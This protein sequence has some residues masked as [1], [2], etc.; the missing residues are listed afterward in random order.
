[1]TLQILLIE[2][3]PDHIELV[4]RAFEQGNHLLVVVA[5]LAEAQ[6]RLDEQSFDLIICDL[7][8]PDGRG[9][10]LLVAGADGLTLPVVLMTGYGDERAAVSA[11][12]SGALDYVAKTPATLLDLP[13]I[14]ERAL[15]ERRLIIERQQAEQALRRSERLFRAMIERSSDAISMVDR[16]GFIRYA[17]PSTQTLLGY[18]TEGFLTQPV[19]GFAFIHPADRERVQRLFFDI[20]QQSG[21]SAMVEFRARHANGG[22]RWIEA[23][24]SNWLDDPAVQG[25]IVNYR[26][27]TE[28]KLM[29]L[30]LQRGVLHDA[31]TG[32]P[33][34]VLLSDRLG[35][36]IKRSQRNP[37]YHFAV[38]FLDL[39]HFKV[40]ND[41]FGH[42]VG[43]RFLVTAASR[44]HSCLRSTDTC[45]R[46][47]GDEF[48][49]LLDD[50]H[51]LDAVVQVAR[52]IIQQLSLPVEVDAQMLHSSVSIGIVF[53][54]AEYN[55]P[56][57]VLRDAD[58][59]MYRA[60]ASGK[61]RYEVFHPAMREA[62]QARLALENELRRAV[63]QREFIVYYQPIMNISSGGLIGFEAL[64]RWQ[65][66]KRGILTPA[67]FLDVAEEVGLG[68]AIGWQVLEHV[69][70][71]LATWQHSFPHAAHLSVSVNLSARQFTQPD[72]YVRIVQLLTQHNIPPNCLKLELT[73]SALM[74]YSQEAAAVLARLRSY[75]IQIAIDDFGVG[76]SSL[77]YLIQLPID[78]IKIDRNFIIQLDQ[79]HHSQAIVSAIV[80]LA[81]SLD[82][83]VVAEGLETTEQVDRMRTVG[84]HY[85]QGY[86]LGY[87]LPA[88][89]ASRLLQ[90]G[91]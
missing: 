71:Q 33:N 89:E 18:P 6:Q 52:R 3:N 2:D 91:E 23:T 58:I 72:L 55:D 87:P 31:L 70:R 78:Q 56:A 20:I 73:E 34:R 83:E 69:C 30:R 82:L 76:Y 61:S 14:A 10:E 37:Q 77:S 45:A 29:E 39:D 50:I 47:G 53:G 5:S 12:K 85:G 26:D 84:C 43:D 38:L 25:V 75:G 36:A 1:M 7:L 65:H 81:R 79:A 49:I 80:N 74:E 8:L 42:P 51:S 9:D 16:D 41:S 57:E 54:S 90:G 46:L 60:K 64:V 86:L 4:Q 63:A 68:D 21:A 44:L 59:A 66:P 24:A 13:H 28:R 11:L 48:V 40:I 88:A 15:R 67:A 62:A 19:A 17:S 35:Q 22:W 32:L 27:I